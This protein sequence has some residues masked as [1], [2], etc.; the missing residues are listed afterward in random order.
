MS[1]KII[2]VPGVAAINYKHFSSDN[3]PESILGYFMPCKNRTR[4]EEN[5]DN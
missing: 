1:I 4:I 2:F 3:N 5:L